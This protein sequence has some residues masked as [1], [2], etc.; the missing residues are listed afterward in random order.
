MTLVEVSEASIPKWRSCFPVSFLRLVLVVCVAFVAVVCLDQWQR[1]HFGGISLHGLSGVT[2]AHVG[3][4]NGPSR[5]EIRSRQILNYQ[6]GQALIV[7]IH[8]THC[9]GTSFC[10][11]M[12]AAGPV[13]PHSCMVSAA[14]LWN[15]NNT[16][17]E[18][19]L[20]RTRF[21]MIA[22]EFGRAKRSPLVD[23]D[24][25]TPGVVSIYVTRD[26]M[27]RALA[28]DADV[29][30]RYGP[31]KLRSPELWKQF[32]ESEHTNN[33]ALN[34]ILRT[35]RESHLCAEG[36]A[37]P[38]ECVE[39]AKALLNRFTFVL[40]QAC[41]TQSLWVLSKELG[42][43]PPKLRPAKIHISARERINNTELYNFITRRMRR[44]IELYQW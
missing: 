29:A 38:A 34:R 7:N 40:D 10:G 4:S 36:E 13:S 15:R 43:P 12:K 24:F 26:P 31:E 30:R 39:K 1:R 28:G 35:T 14:Y 22:W 8:V 19:A 27:D 20:L 41:F 33:F 5:A 17:R 11:Y 18:A 21:H 6:G 32:A 23:V 37:T 2:V 42:L 3:G 16:A 25:E 44:D 9:A